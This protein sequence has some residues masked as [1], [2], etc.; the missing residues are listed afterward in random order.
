[1]TQAP[2]LA[3]YS[4]WHLSLPGAEAL[5]PSHLR[6]S[7]T[8]W[9]SSPTNGARSSPRC[10]VVWTLLE[11]TR[12]PQALV[13]AVGSTYSYGRA[14]HPLVFGSLAGCCSKTA[15]RAVQTSIARTLLMMLPVSYA[16]K[17]PKPLITSSST[18]ILQGSSG[19]TSDGTD[20]QCHPLQSFG[21]CPGHPT[22]QLLLLSCWHIWNHRHDVLF[23][24]QPLCLRRLLS[25]CKE[26]CRLWSCRLRDQERV[27]TDTRCNLFSM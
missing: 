3:K 15:F 26:A 12:R 25:S 23:R 14:G 13:R 7:W 6:G 17:L 4:S 1:M 18:A 11:S 16:T 24:H 2:L 8:P 9:R 20:R 22:C 21:T 5:P 27:L 10:R 19:I